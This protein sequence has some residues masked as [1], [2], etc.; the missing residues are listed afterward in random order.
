MSEKTTGFFKNLFTLIGAVLVITLV[1]YYTRMKTPEVSALA[2][3]PAGDRLASASTDGTLK[4]WDMNTGQQAWSMK[5][6]D[7]GRVNA[8]RLIVQKPFLAISPEGHTLAAGNLFG[9]I[10]L[11]DVNTGEQIQTLESN[12]RWRSL[13]F[14][15]DGNVLAAESDDSTITLWDLKTGK[16]L[17]VLG[18]KQYP[19]T[20]DYI[21]FSP[22]GKILAQPNW[23]GTI[24][25]WDVA[26]GELAL[27][28]G[29]VDRSGIVKREILVLMPSVAFSPD[30]GVLASSVNGK[31]KLW[32]ASS[33][34]E[35]HTLT[36]GGTL[37]MV[38]FSPDGKYL[39]SPDRD[40][41]VHLWEVSTGEWFATFTAVPPKPRTM[42]LLNTLLAIRP[43]IAFSPDGLT[44]ALGSR[45]NIIMAWD[46]QTGKALPI[47][48]H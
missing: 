28:F 35:L 12:I 10:R 43:Y 2:F 9:A 19:L 8:N 27:Q 26:T 16:V 4:V 31:I 17:Q 40:D 15:P 30:G 18:K 7:E 45:D 38:A 37:G 24:K 36:T 13:A 20:S 5:D 22:D 1:F 6:P 14:S 25:L 29:G 42:K 41:T 39:A 23:N 48:Q 47:I 33:G 11:W 3:N 21:A 32:E 44:L 46:V 34:K